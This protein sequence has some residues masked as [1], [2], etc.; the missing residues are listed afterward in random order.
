MLLEV[1]LRAYLNSFVRELDE[2]LRPGRPRSRLPFEDAIPRPE[3]RI[4]LGG[5]ER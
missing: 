2:I 4:L 3:G 1:C 5:Y